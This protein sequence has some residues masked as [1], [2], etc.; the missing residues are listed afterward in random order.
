PDIVAANHGDGTVSILLG[1][2]DGTFLPQSVYD[3]GPM[4][5]GIALADLDGDGKLD[6]AVANYDYTNDYSDGTVTVLSNRGDGTFGAPTITTFGLAP[7]WVTVGDVNGD[8]L[9]DLVVAN[10][11]S[12]SVTVLASQ[13][14]GVAGDVYT[15]DG[16]TGPVSLTFSISGTVFLDANG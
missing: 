15:I 16:A 11:N 5:L 12:G 13:S 10:R 6:I 9:P 7:D 2:G 8:G 3:V 1:R 14:A 4:P